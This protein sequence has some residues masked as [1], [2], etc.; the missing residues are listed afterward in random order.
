MKKGFFE[1]IGMSSLEKVHSE[2]LGW[3][4]S[5]SCHATADIR[6]D[7]LNQLTNKAS[8]KIQSPISAITVLAVE[9]KSFDIYIETKLKN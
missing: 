3:L 1:F 8:I 9:Y 6:I 2:V 4:L 7:L 5:D